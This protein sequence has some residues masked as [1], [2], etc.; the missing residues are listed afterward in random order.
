MR[1]FLEQ[2][3][4]HLLRALDEELESPQRLIVVV[5]PRRVTLTLELML[6]FVFGAVAS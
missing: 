5:D 3:F 1:S 4:V 6:D 2:E